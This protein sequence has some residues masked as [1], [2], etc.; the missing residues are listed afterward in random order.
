MK[1]LIFENIK[2]GYVP[3]T[4]VI[5]NNK[6]YLIHGVINGETISVDTSGKYPTLKEVLKKSEHRI[7]YK[8]DECGGATFMHVDYPYEL[9]LK[10][11][12]LID[13]FIKQS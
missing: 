7:D 2:V 4:E 9:K 5:I 6:K 12:H 3:D 1:D 10:E 13:L 11:E 8:V